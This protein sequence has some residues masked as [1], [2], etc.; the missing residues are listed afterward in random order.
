MAE[1]EIAN[2]T[3][4]DPLRWGLRGRRPKLQWTSVLPEQVTKGGPSAVAAITWIRGFAVELGRILGVINDSMGAGLYID[5]MPPGTNR[6]HGA[7]FA[8]PVRGGYIDRDGAGPTR[9]RGGRP[10][11]TVDIGAC[12]TVAAEIGQ[13]LVTAADKADVSEETRRFRDAVTAL[14]IRTRRAATQFNDTG[15]HADDDLERDVKG[16]ITELAAAEKSL[17]TE[18]T[19][20]D[21]LRWKEWLE[22][23]W[24]AG[25][26]R[27]HAATKIPVEWKPSVADMGGGAVSASP[28]N[29]LE[30][31]RTKYARYWDAKDQPIEYDWRGRCP[32][33]DRLTPAQLREASF[34]FARRTA[35]TYDGWHVRQFGLIGDDGLDVL[36]VILEAVETSSRW[37]TQ[38]AVVTTPMLPK[39]KGGHRLIGKLAALYRVWSKARR[40]VADRWEAAHD[41]PF[42][43]S[44]AGSGPIDAVF[45]QAIRHEAAGAS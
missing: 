34:S 11:P 25:A 24:N 8:T 44:A 1:L 32:P 5:P 7:T 40:P 37:P 31:T 12:A 19:K 29:I 17:E 9:P 16:M 42:F 36:A 23:D 10:R 20:E 43:A 2:A 6:P 26:R 3:G 45:R 13:E 33:L 18:R 27:G 39:P 35:R 14:A 4:V 38:T 28:L 22:A 15:M 21:K 41:E 30:A